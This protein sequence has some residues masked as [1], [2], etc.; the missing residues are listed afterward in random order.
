MNNPLKSLLIEGTLG[1]RE[2]YYKLCSEYL[3]IQTGIWQIAIYSVSIFHSLDEDYIFNISSDLVIGHKYQTG[4]LK[5]FEVVLNQFKINKNIHKEIILNTN[6]SWFI[7]NN[8]SCEHLTI[9][10]DEWPKTPT[11]K[12]LSSAL[13]GVTV[14][15]QRLM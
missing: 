6:P 2:I 7:I 15:F 13:I 11:P 1:S 12:K 8:V 5:R 3:Q 10:F 9:Y 14:N 4:K